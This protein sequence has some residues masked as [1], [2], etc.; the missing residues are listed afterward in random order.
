MA[1]VIEEKW[2]AYSKAVASGDTAAAATLLKEVDLAIRAQA[3]NDPSPQIKEMK[4]TA[5]QLR[6]DLDAAQKQLDALARIGLNQGRGYSLVPSGKAQRIQMLRDKRAFMDDETARR[7]GAHFAAKICRGPASKIR[8]EELPKY[9]RDTAEDVEKVAGQFKA[10]ANISPDISGAGQELISNEFRAE[11]IRNVEAVG[12]AFT[13]FRRVPLAT[14]GKT[15]YPRRVY[16]TDG[17]GG[18]TA[19]PTAIAAK[20]R[21]SGVAFGSVTLAPNEW[22][23]LSGIPTIM[24][25]DPG[26]LVDLGQLVGTETVYAMSDAWDNAVING[27]GSADYAMITGVLQSSDVASVAPTQSHTTVAALDALDVGYIDGSLPVAYAY[28]DA[29]W[30]MHLSVFQA[31]RNIRSAT[32]A[33]GAQVFGAPIYQR[34]DGENPATIDGYPYTICKRMPVAAN[35]TA[36]SKFAAFGNFEMSHYF[37]ILR[38]LKIDTSADV[39]FDQNMVAVRGIAYVD[40]QESDP[41]CLIAPAVHA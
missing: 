7:F 4:A 20:I 32:A 11:L 1:N 19:Y 33:G 9:T 31:M 6:K 5:E 29:S 15:I 24:F 12:T 25:L 34:G 30:L 35:V 41:H 38:E 14:F 16:N 40:F 26:L 28:N 13:K 18:L 23:V 3:G 22:A 10:D 37:G 17:T 2:T 39:W 8:Y 36:G 27:D 21:Q